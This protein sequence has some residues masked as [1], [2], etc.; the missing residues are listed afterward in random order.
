LALA[1]KYHTYFATQVTAGGT[2]ALWQDRY[3]GVGNTPCYSFAIKDLPRTKRFWNWTMDTVPKLYMD[4]VISKRRWDTAYADF[5]SLPVKGTHRLEPMTVWAHR[6]EP[7]FTARMGG[8]FECRIILYGYDVNQSGSLTNP[9]F[10]FEHP[11]SR[12]IKQ[13]REEAKVFW[14]IACDENNG[15]FARFA[16]LAS[17][18]WLWTWANPFMRSGALISDALS[19]VMQKQLRCQIRTSFY[20]QDV[21]ALLL[22]FNVYVE[23]RIKDMQSGFIPLFRM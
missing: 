23:K 22:P 1:Q 3:Q 6:Y 5:P 18:E 19:L 20:H 16:A 10:L 2:K 4:S 9:I 8:A 7:R 12:W 17:W 21:E 15:R 11:R 14:N 13:I